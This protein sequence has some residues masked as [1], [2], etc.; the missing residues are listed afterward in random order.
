MSAP[1]APPVPHLFFCPYCRSTEQVDCVEL[2]GP[3]TTEYQYR[4]GACDAQGSRQG[5]AREAKQAWNY[6]ALCVIALDY[7]KK[8]QTDAAPS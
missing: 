4:C 5:T 1:D 3:S 8:K 6:V 7:L 2:L